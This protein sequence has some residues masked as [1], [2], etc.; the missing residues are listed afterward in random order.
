MAVGHEIARSFPAHHVS[1]RNRPGRASQ[2]SKPGHEFQIDGCSKKRILLAPD[3]R[4]G[5]FLDGRPSCQEEI[6]R[7]QTQAFG[8]I[9]FGRIVVVAG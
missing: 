6:C 2:I 8:H 9:F 3:R 4:S 7:I 1:R 5:K